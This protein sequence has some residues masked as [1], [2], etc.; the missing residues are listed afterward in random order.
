M[1]PPFSRLRRLAPAIIAGSLV[2]TGGSPARWLSGPEATSQRAGTL[3]AFEPMPTVCVMPAAEQRAAMRQEYAAIQAGRVVE[4]RG[5]AGAD[6][7]GSLSLL[8]RCVG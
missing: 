5:D 8:R 3:V 4:R 7:Q 1:S 6:D 2:L